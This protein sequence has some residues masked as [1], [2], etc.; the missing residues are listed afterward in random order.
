[1]QFKTWVNEFLDLLFPTQ[2]VV[3][4][5]WG[6]G[7]CL[8]CFAGSISGLR[9]FRFA[10]DAGGFLPGLSLGSYVGDLRSLILSAKHDRVLDFSI[11][12]EAVGEV[13][14][15]ELALDLDP[16][17]EVVVVPLPS[18]WQRVWRGMLVTPT[19][20]E[21]VARGCDSANLVASVEDGL[22]FFSEGGLWTA[23]KQL[24]GVGGSG[25]QRGKSGVSRRGSRRGTMGVRGD[26]TGKRVILV[27]DV[28]TTGATMREGMRVVQLAGG[29]VVGIICLANLEKTQ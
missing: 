25:S 14:G 16:L 24:W 2:C 6:Q 13:L 5:E 20:A 18:H 19:L 21:G 10:L 4:G 1:M 8:R 26:F 28:V 17:D 11:W 7:L 27:D 29:E 15:V 12:L 3:C 23:F 9:R 22:F